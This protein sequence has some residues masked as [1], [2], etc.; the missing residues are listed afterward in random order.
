MAISRAE[1]VDLQQGTTPDKRSPRS[2]KTKAS[3]KREA[4]RR[5]AEEALRQSDVPFRRYFDLGLIGMAIT[6]PTKGIIEVN[7]ELCRI[8]G[9]GRNELLQKSW[10]EMTH[11]EDLAADEAQFKRVLGG[12]IDGYSLEKRW[13]RKDGCVI[14]SI[15]SAKCERRPDESV[16]YFVGLVLDITER[17]RAE[18]AQRK[19]AALVEN[20]SDFIGLASL[21]AKALYVNRAGRDLVGAG[22]DMPRNILDYMMEEDRELVAEKVLPKVLSQGSWEGELRM[23]HFETGA[24]IPMHVK[25]FLIREEGTERALALATISRDITALK[26]AEEELRRSEAYL[27]QSE[28]LSQT[29]RAHV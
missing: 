11:P 27:A 19:L 3:R 23:R 8:L 24:A 13:I 12:E 15:M 21:D 22:A 20:S 2:P 14:D 29:G 26:K 10:P 16:D 25:G 5:K 17:K 4:Q 28:R 6:S 1:M 18:E 9:Y 7:D